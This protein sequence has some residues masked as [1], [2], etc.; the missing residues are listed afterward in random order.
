[1]NISYKDMHAYHRTQ[2]EL[3]RDINT[4]FAEHNLASATNHLSE[5]SG[6][7]FT[8]QMLRDLADEYE[9]KL[10]P[11]KMKLYEGVR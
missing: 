5:Q 7:P 2:S 6:I 10:P 1:M 3:E 11:S 4:G 8:V 9:S